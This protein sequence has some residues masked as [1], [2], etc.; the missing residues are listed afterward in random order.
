MLHIPFINIFYYSL[1]YSLKYSFIEKT[2][3]EK[4]DI[5]RRNMNNINNTKLNED[6][7]K[8]DWGGLVYYEPNLDIASE[9]LINELDKLIEIHA[10]LKKVS[11]RKQKYC[12]KPWIDKEM[13]AELKYKNKIASKA[14]KCPTEN[15]KFEY[16]KLKNATTSK[17]RSKKQV[18]LNSYFEK[19]RND[20]KRMW[21]G[22]NN[23]MESSKAK[24]NAPMTVTDSDKKLLSC[25]DEIANSFA[26]YFE[27]VPTKTRNKIIHNNLHKRNRHY[28]EYLHKNRP[29]DKYLTLHVTNYDEV[30]KHILKLNDR[31]S[32][33]PLS[34]P[35]R[36]LKIIS[37]PLSQLM[38]YI[39]NISMSNGYVPK[40]FKVGK[41]TP[42][43]KSGAAN[44][45][46]YR[47]ITVCNSL[48][49]ILEKIVRLRVINHLKECK[50]LTDSQ[51]GFRS[52][53]STNHAMINLLEITLSALDNNL[54]TGGIFLD[55]SKAFDCVDHDKLLKKLE[56]YG[57]RANALMWFQSYLQD[58]QQFVSIRNSRSKSY[59]LEC[60]VPQGGTLAPI[61]FILYIN[62][63]IHSSSV[64]DFSIYADDTCLILGINREEYNNTVNNEIQN[65]MNW[66]T[67][68]DLLVNVSKTDYLHFGP[69]YRK[70]Y[71]KGEHDMSEFHNTVPLYLVESEDPSDPDHHTL[72]IKGKFSMHELGKVCPKYIMQENIQTDDGNIIVEN[73]KVKYLGLYFDNTLL[74]RHQ[75]ALVSC[76]INRMVG[77]I[78]KMPDI[79]IDVKKIIYHSLVESQLNY[80]I[81]IWASNISKN[82]FGTYKKGHVPNNLKVVKK[83]QNK[84]IRAIF[85]KPKYDKKT[86][87]PI[88][89]SVLYKELQV[90]KLYDLYYYNL[91][92]LCF[93]YFSTKGLPNKINGYFKRKSEVNTLNTRSSDFDL[94]NST[95]RLSSTYRKPCLV[96]ASFWNTL[97]KELKEIDS[98]NNFKQ[99]LK[100]Y[101]IDEY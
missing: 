33:G 4:P 47:P 48:S 75:I 2:D 24:K 20:S 60:G 78:W 5:Y 77:I 65:V 94:Y 99:K 64:F 3:K 79:S 76:K 29:I 96:G 43:F 26:N 44:I 86:K 74:F 11:K 80:G 82:I 85:R 54:K 25:P 15:N 21:T 7:Q 56:Y 63:I 1:K 35:N 42:V 70:V 69:I 22:I 12:T 89:T 50:I 58:R 34:V 10:P 9:N 87:T 18:Y 90:L 19:H 53:H 73:E 72:N 27:Q 37:K 23:A 32:P 62:D 14:K 83:S 81:L 17:L 92:M 88:N 61:L 13:Q 30:E 91:G 31:S 93:D 46:N 68:N 40:V 16:K 6:F 98:K 51:Y 97:P 84:V 101:F 55:I 8:I 38:T 100:K 95:P 39:I 67:S 57:F 52:M 71:I 49:K 45:E 28:L 41:Q 59:K 36:F 66:F